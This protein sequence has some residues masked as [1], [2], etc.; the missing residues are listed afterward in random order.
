LKTLLLV[1]PRNGSWEQLQGSGAPLALMHASVLARQRY[2]IRLLDLRRHR[3]ERARRA[4]LD[5]VRSESP[6]LVGMTVM[7]GPQLREA[8]QLSRQLRSSAPDLPIVWGGVF[9]AS[10]P[11]LS[12]AEPSVTAIVRGE[13]ERTLLELAAALEQAAPLHEIPGISA[14]V[15]DT[16]A[17]GPERAPLDLD[18]LPPLDYDLLGRR[19]QTSGFRLTQD[20]PMESSRGCVHDCAFCY[21][22][23]DSGRTWRARSPQRMGEELDALIARARPRGVFFVDDNFFASPERGLAVARQVARRGLSWEAHGVTPAA[24][25]AMDGPVLDELE[26]AP[27]AAG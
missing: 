1:Q 22:T 13:G 25:V 14:R 4:L 11:D 7:L 16:V 21:N 26:R 12:L 10:V 5:A 19:G 8:L 27:A 18:D 9:P 17:N 24:A 23:A 20:V 3:G 6:L 15:G 2:R